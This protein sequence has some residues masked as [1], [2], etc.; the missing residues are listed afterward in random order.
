MALTIW[1]IPYLIFKVGL[2]NFGIYTFAMALILFLQNV[3]NYG[4]NLATVREIAKNKN[5]KVK[6]NQIF[7][8]VISGK[9]FL[10]FFI[11][12]FL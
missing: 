1:L 7:S 12:S 6:L 8:E 5:D 10:L 2:D 3:L 11:F 9:L 4:F